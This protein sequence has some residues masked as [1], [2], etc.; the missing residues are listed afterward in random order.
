MIGARRA[1]RTIAIA[2]TLGA[3]LLGGC[4]S[5]GGSSGDKA[6]TTTTAATSTTATST[7]SAAVTTTA[8]AGTTA[9][10]STT[11]GP[12]TTVAGGK[13]GGTPAGLDVLPDGFYYGYFHGVS[14]GT[15]NGQSVQ[16]LA[17]DEVQFF[18]GQAAVD[19]AHAHHAIPASQDYVD[20]DYYLL[21]TNPRIRHLAIVPDA[22]VT[23]LKSAGSAEP[24]PSSP[25]EVATQPYLFKIQMQN[26]RGESTITSVEAVFLP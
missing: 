18:T 23:S 7:T 9:A 5:S 25:D 13:D 1:T 20:D 4:S 8:A 2:A 10:T 24:V 17:F 14:G 21:N 15:I 26:V 12:T 19:Q 16:V 11:G 3:L 22:Q 6:A